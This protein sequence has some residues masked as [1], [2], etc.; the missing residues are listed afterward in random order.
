MAG[1]IPEHSGKFALEFKNAVSLQVAGQVLA[2][3]PLKQFS[4]GT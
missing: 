1:V 2:Y 3:M 4:R